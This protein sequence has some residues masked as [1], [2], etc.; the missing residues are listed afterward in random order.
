M[1]EDPRV[2]FGE[3]ALSRLPVDLS[4]A[5]YSRAYL[6]TTRGRAET[7]KEIRN[8][9]GKSLIDVF[10]GAI[11]HVPVQVTGVAEIAL[12]K[13]NPDVI[14][15]LGGGS[16][17]GLAK[18]L[19]LRTGLPLVA[20]PTTY[21]GSEMTSIYGETN[22]SGKKTGRDS[23]V[24]PR[25]IFY[26]PK[27]TCNL[28]AA[29]SAASGLNALAHSIE[30][31]YAGNATSFSNQRAEES[32]RLLTQSLP[33]VVADP[34]DLAARSDA[35]RGAQ[36]AGEALNST[37]MGLHHRICHV[38]GGMFRLPH[39]KTHSVMLR[40]VVAYNFNAAPDAMRRIET[41]MGYGNAVAG[42]E[43]LCASLPVP[44]SLQEIGFRKSDIEP[45]AREIAAGDYPNPRPVTSESVTIVLKRAFTGECAAPLSE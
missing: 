24:V 42:V 6:V 20:I 44:A 18:A 25:I 9:M 43:S 41:I 4:A 26:D 7:V 45:A 10:S 33:R 15:A 14:I 3:G 1:T 11:E 8:L 32:I 19:V 39:A 5:G 29:V 37:S 28:P 35:L 13:A 36:F 34:V 30:A 17:I 12:R 22:E 31:L 38:L 27:L 40:F 23:R 16:P 2:V 21:S